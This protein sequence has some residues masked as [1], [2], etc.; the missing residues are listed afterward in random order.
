MRS[1]FRDSMV[2]LE[3]RHLK[4]SRKKLYD[5]KRYFEKALR[6]IYT[7]PPWVSLLLL[8]ASLPQKKGKMKKIHKKL[9]SLSMWL[10]Y[11]F[12]ITFFQHLYS[13]FICLIILLKSLNP[14]CVKKNLIYSDLYI[15]FFFHRKVCWF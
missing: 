4:R 1:N 2:Y 8:V 11:F 5:W 15:Y 12:F 10:T 9:W 3:M 13:R 6:S 7:R 14:L